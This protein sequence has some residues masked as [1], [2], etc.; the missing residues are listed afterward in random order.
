[1]NN[2]ISIIVPVY[3]VERYINTCINSIINQSYRN[4]EILLI[5]DGSK[6][7]SGEICDKWAKK[8]SR[9]KVFH[10]ENG[11]LSD[12]RNFGINKCNGEYLIFIDSDDFINKDMVKKLLKLSQENEADIVQCEFLKFKNENEIKESNDKNKVQVF[13]NIEAIENHYKEELKISTVVSWSK[14][15]KK[16]LFNDIRFPKGKLHEDEFTTY[17]LLYKANKVLYTNEKLYYYRETPNSIM[18]SKY[19]IRR[20]DLLEALNERLLFF[21]K[22][23]NDNLYNIALN[24]Y[25]S[26]LI[27][28]YNSYK[29]FNKEDKETLN[30]LKKESKRV[31]NELNSKGLINKKDIILFTAF[32]LNSFYYRV[33][34]KLLKY[35]NKFLLRQYY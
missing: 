12:A 13:K 14:L 6:D 2:L 1:M 26:I 33:I 19:N 16:Y 24:N 5:N 27:F 29:K 8:D 7:L 15:Y 31:F 25:Y 18:N 32:R 23:N 34:K 11:G 4:I 3:N 17:K 28:A 10:K 20:L 9:I 21:K 35:N 30:K 22:I